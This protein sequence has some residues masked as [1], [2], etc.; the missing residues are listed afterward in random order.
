MI[1]I[2]AIIVD[3]PESHVNSLNIPDG[4]IF[5][6]LQEVH[7]FIQNEVEPQNEIQP[8]HEK[9]TF[10]SSNNKN[11]ENKEKDWNESFQEALHLPASTLEEEQKRSGT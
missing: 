4:Q 3:Q 11:N 2:D 6:S 5:N 8:K 7:S 1:Y 10:S 9:I